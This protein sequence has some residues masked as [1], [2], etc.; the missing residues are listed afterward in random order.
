MVD[1]KKVN[2]NSASAFSVV[3]H[4]HVIFEEAY[5]GDVK[6]LDQECTIPMVLYNAGILYLKV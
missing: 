5:Y 3:S 2:S 1:N 4:E 6:K